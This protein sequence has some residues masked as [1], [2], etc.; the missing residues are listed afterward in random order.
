MVAWRMEHLYP[1]SWHAKRYRFRQSML[2]SSQSP[3]DNRGHCPLGNYLHHTRCGKF[4]C[5]LD[6]CWGTI[7]KAM[8]KAWNFA[9]RELARLSGAGVKGMHS[10]TPSGHSAR[11]DL[12]RSLQI[13]WID[14]DPGHD[15]AAALTLAGRSTSNSVV[16]KGTLPKDMCREKVWLPQAGKLK[17]TWSLNLRVSSAIGN[18]SLQNRECIE[19]PSCS[20]H[21]HR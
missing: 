3:G 12:L 15:G 9:L 11:A 8:Q 14:C 5:M 17:A 1:P 19:S 4:K 7:G 6:R 10:C 18:S 2:T 16:G 20:R 13:A 21:Q